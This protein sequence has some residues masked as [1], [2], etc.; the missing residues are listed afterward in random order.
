MSDDALDRIAPLLERLK[1]TPLDAALHDQGARL[2]LRHDPLARSPIQS[3]LIGP[4]LEI[5]FE[6]DHVNHQDLAA[7]ALDHLTARYGIREVGHPR[8]AD[9]VSLMAR[10]RLLLSSLRRL[11]N[12]NVGFELFLRDMRRFLLMSHE[13][14]HP[15]PGAR[16]A[17]IEALAE[18]CF[19]NEYVMIE[20]A[21]EQRT[22][23]AI[24]ERLPAVLDSDVER[25]MGLL[26]LLAMYRPLA[27][28]AV[29]GRVATTPMESLSETLQRGVRRLILEPLQEARL[30]ETIASLGETAC[31]TSRAV[32]E[33]YE[34]NPYPRWFSL[35]RPRESEISRSRRDILVAG[36]GTG[37]HPL[38]VA[39]RNPRS[40]ILALDLSKASLAYAKRLSQALNIENV[41]FL[42]GDLL[43]IGQ[44][45]RRF[46][47]I[48]C[49]GVLHHLRD[50]DAGWAALD[51][52]LLPGGSLHISVYSQ[53]ARMH[54][55]FLRREI[56]ERGIPPTADAIRGFRH[57]LLTN[58]RYRTLRPYCQ[59]LDS[60][61]VS[62]FRD[63]LF[64]ACESR[65]TL[66]QIANLIA[67]HHLTFMRFDPLV[68]RSTYL[69]LHP[70]DPDMTSFD[71]WRRFEPYYAGTNVMLSFWLRKARA[72]AI[73]AVSGLC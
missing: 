16:V 25:G 21:E 14:A 50:P 3:D 53:V 23:R 28:S 33:Q 61:T 8:P 7:L 6:Q 5:L 73:R 72:G 64:H 10:D 58:E 55:K 18:Q 66:A 9:I 69:A 45:G 39:V 2:L 60:F 71:A 47:H 36:C 38:A 15:I 49:S 52:A 59:T 62:E 34:Q 27:W 56:A 31:D 54:V 26:F 22:V 1:E 43:E 63:Y 29:A 12:I 30:S 51:D 35:G 48:E 65:Y 19:N 11:V 67:R 57:E 37:R 24:E 13:R 4:L 42:Q 20:S 46:D 17:L 32:R 41:T 68:L 44:L 70:E 40:S